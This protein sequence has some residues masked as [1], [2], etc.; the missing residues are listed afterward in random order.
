[1]NVIQNN[2][3]RILGLLVGASATQLNR[4]RTRIPKYIIARDEIPEE[5]TAYS[6]EILGCIDRTEDIITNAGSK[7]N[8]DNDKI[9]AALFWFWNGNPITDEVAFD[10]LKEGDTDT[11][12]EIWQKMTGNDEDGYNEITKRNASA[13]YNL[14][15]LYLSEYG[16]DEDSLQLKLRFLESDFI[17]EFTTQVTDEHFKI[18]KKDLQLLFLQSLSQDEDFDISAFFEAISNIE[19]S[20]KQDFLKKFVQKPILQIKQQIEEAKIKRKANKASGY[21]AG[22]ELFNAVEKVITQLKNILGINDIRFSSISDKVAEEILQCGI[23]YFNHFSDSNTDPSS[24]AMDLFRKANTFAVGSIVRQRIQENTENLQKWIDDKPERDKQ[25]RIAVDFEQLKNLIDR[26]ENLPETVANAKQLLSSAR[27]Y[28]NNVKNVLGS[29]DKLHLGLSSRIAA[30]ALGMCVSEIN[31]LQQRFAYTFDPTSELRIF[32]LLKDKVNEAL[33]VTK[34]ISLMD[35]RSDFRNH[36]YQNESS[37]S[38]LRRQLSQHSTGGGGRG[39]FSSRTSTSNGNW[40]EEN[41]G[42]LIALIIVAIF[43]LILIFSN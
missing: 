22:K 33:E 21:N 38:N 14:S 8:L 30:D 35:L 13:F 24:Y 23:D 25:K 9:N 10:A 15:T 2:P 1:M 31:I 27:P 12:I 36:F 20:A 7:L 3:Y 34:T 28:L 17:K 37:L 42:C 39:G 41:P 29:T 11:A 4:H 43:F 16:I 6:F 19:F 32:F 26:Y 40:A 5:F 18:T